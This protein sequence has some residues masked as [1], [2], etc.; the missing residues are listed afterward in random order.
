MTGNRCSSDTSNHDFDQEVFEKCE[1]FSPPIL[2]VQIKNIRTVV[3][4]DDSK[5]V[6]LVQAS[7]FLKGG[8]IARTNS[9][10]QKVQNDTALPNAHLGSSS[11][12]KLDIVEGIDSLSLADFHMQKNISR[13]NK[14]SAIIQKNKIIMLKTK[15]SRQFFFNRSRVIRK[16]YKRANKVPKVVNLYTGKSSS[17]D[18][19]DNE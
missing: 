14:K 15:Q 6:V 18:D 12:N 4:E 11:G 17:N 16:K 13:F 2:Q 5:D 3:N 1:D 8:V 19:D 7:H 10:K 9:S